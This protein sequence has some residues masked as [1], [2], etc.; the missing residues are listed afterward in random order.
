ML[1]LDRGMS[2]RGSSPELCPGVGN[3]AFAVSF[4]AVEK[5]PGGE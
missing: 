3:E 4:K 1:R 2:K 5:F